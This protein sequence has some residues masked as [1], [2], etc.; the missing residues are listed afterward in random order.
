M[1]QGLCSGGAANDL[2]HYRCGFSPPCSVISV[3]LKGRDQCT[4]TL[5]LKREVRIKILSFECET[6]L[7][8]EYGVKAVEYK[9]IYPDH[10]WL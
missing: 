2:L 8:I 5:P 4:F 10:T 7:F 9:M 3:V 6:R 1:L